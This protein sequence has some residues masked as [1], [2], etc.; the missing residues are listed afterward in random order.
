M[1]VKFS[2][3]SVNMAANPVA[4]L[5][6]KVGMAERLIDRVAVATTDIDNAD[7]TIFFGPIPSNAVISSIRIFNDDLD[8][9][10]TPTLACNVGLFYS[11]TGG[12]QIAAGRVAGDVIDV[13]CFATAITTLQ[14][15]NVTGVEVRFEAGDIADIQKEAWEIGGLSSD[16]GGH[17]LIGLDLTTAAATAVAGD[18]VLVV[19]YI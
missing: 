2:V 3:N 12:G 10:G 11:G 6:R 9:N 17:F 14:S 4:I 1:G 16:I 15:A 7:D 19:D 8:S 13:D 5:S 18:I